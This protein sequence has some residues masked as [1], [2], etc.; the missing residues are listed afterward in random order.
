MLNNINFKNSNK[1]YLKIISH[2]FYIN[3]EKTNI[4]YFNEQF[5]LFVNDVV[6]V[7][8][9]LRQSVFEYYEEL[10]KNETCTNDKYVKRYM[11]KMKGYKEQIAKRDNSLFDSTIC[12]LKNV[13]FSPIWKSQELS[14]ANRDTIW[15]YLQTLYVIGETIISDSEHIQKLVK[16]FQ[17]F[18][19]GEEVSE[20]ED[21]VTKDMLEMLQGLSETNKEKVSEIYENLIKNGLIGNLAKELSEELSEHNLNLDMDNVESVDDVFKNIMSGDNPMKFMN[22]LQTVG[23]KIQSK[24]DSNE[25]DGEKLVEEATSMM[26]QMGGLGGGNGGLF[27]SLLKNVGSIAGMM[28]GSGGLAAMMGGV[29]NIAQNINAATSNPHHSSSNSTRDRL[30]RKLENRRKEQDDV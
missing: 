2:L 18:K 27:D 21:S 28:G 5:S 8:P 3:M 26:S 4:E 12:V 23:K 30:R 13:D 16:S 22:L 15:E 19:N 1:S 20:E 11:M 17:K 25:I 9:E 7:F 24:V 14:N 6:E 10:F 29:G